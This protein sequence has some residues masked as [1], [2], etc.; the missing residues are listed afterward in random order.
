MAIFSG[1]TTAGAALALSLAISWAQE[2]TVARWHI[3]G[4]FMKFWTLSLLVWAAWGMFIW[5]LVMSPIRHLPGPSGNHWLFGQGL[6][7]FREPT[8]WPMLEWYVLGVTGEWV[9]PERDRQL[10]LTC[11]V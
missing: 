7:A 6:R 5:P 8:G 3:I 4:L 10:W 9:T 1:Q 2:G 11:G